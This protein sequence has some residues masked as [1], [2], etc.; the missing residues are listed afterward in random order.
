MDWV[1][2]KDIGEIAQRI[3]DLDFQLVSLDQCGLLI[4]LLKN[5]LEQPGHAWDQV[6]QVYQNLFL[7]LRNLCTKS[8]D[9]Q[10][11]MFQ[12]NYLPSL[13]VLIESLFDSHDASKQSLCHKVSFI[14]Q[15]R[16]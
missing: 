8:S 13:K 16:F 10:S 6:N 9:Y 3:Q 15:T 1:E 5:L 4:Q 12:S 2:S 7:I 14:L 11:L